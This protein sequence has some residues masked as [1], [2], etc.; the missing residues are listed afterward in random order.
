[1]S[2][3]NQGQ[4]V[5][6]RF[7]PSPTGHLHIGSLRTALFNWLFARHNGGAFLIRIED[8]DTERS[9]AE[10]TDAIFDALAWTGLQGDEKTV[11]QSERKDE[12]IKLIDRLCQEG[13][14]Y[15]CYCTKD[16]LVTR[17]SQANEESFYVRY[18]GHCRDRVAD[19]TDKPYVIRFKIPDACTH[20][21]FDDLIRGAIR[22][23]RD[24]LDDFI[25][26]RSDG[27][28]M[29]NFVVVADD[30]FMGITHVIRGEDHIS[31]TP[32][33]ILLYEA[34][35]LAI[36][37]FAHLPM[38]LGP[39]GDRLSKRDG[40][41]GTGEYRRDGYLA[42]ALLN[43]LARLGWSH[44]DQEIFTRDEMV[45]FFSLASVGKKGAIFDQQKLLWTNS[46]HIRNS[47]CQE[48]LTQIEQNID[49]D[50]RIKVNRWSPEQLEHVTTLYK[51][52]VNTLC[53]LVESL[54]AL[55]DG[56]KFFDMNGINVGDTKQTAEHMRAFLETVSAVTEWDQTILTSTIKQVIAQ[57]GIKFVHLAQ[58]IRIALS[59][60]TGGPGVSEMLVAVG[61]Q[62]SIRRLHTFIDALSGS[63]EGGKGKDV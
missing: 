45:S 11:T 50:I 53:E 4:A 27:N 26:M 10:Y 24:Q 15:R 56:P 62:E 35:D 57:Q 5:R 37:D 6:V 1:M 7:A 58:P 48:L 33:Q 20:V 55:H 32:K 44:G 8:T 3:E 25:I 38:I 36:P 54:V 60:I 41:T 42:D 63:M 12:H 52:R 14:A 29:Y 23:D 31:N 59:G 19:N 34:L 2:K 40:A 61:K 39:S 17:F 51:E 46:V 49:P 9:K 18:D 16:E 21:S 47:S 30:A 43:Y 13:K 22:F 28:P